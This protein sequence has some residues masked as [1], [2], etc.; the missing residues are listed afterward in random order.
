LRVLPQRE[1]IITDANM[2]YLLNCRFAIW[3]ALGLASWGLPIPSHDDPRQAH[4]HSI[5]TKI[6][7]SPKLP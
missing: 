7:L 2:R 5:S 1:R 4:F 6:Q 3:L